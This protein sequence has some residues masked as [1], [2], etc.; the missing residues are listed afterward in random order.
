MDCRVLPNSV[1]PDPSEVRFVVPPPTAVVDLTMSDGAV[2]RVRRHGNAGGNR[3]ILSHGNGFAIDAYFPFW[4]RLVRDFEII[5]FDQRNHGWN[6]R[7][8]SGHTQAQMANDMEIILRAVAAEFGPRPIAGAFHSL[9]T[10]VSLLHAMKYSYRWDALILFDPPL[11]PPP[12]HR[13]HKRARDF[14]LALSQWSLHRQRLFRN[15]AE[16]ADYFKNARRLRHWVPG[17]AELM[18]SAVTRPAAGGGVELVCPPELEADIYVQNSNAPAWQALPHL[19]KDL[20]V[21]SS[22]PDEPHPD[23]PGLVS[24]ALRADFGISV[25]PVRGS[26]HLLMIEQPEAVE[27]V[28]RG[29]LRERGFA[30]G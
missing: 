11:A 23:P 28:L 13:L 26:G 27:H 17:A 30:V 12:G 1:G 25:V 18:A 16:L 15:T 8:T 9:S 5:L 24:Q 22:D 2:I 4:Q 19:A 29:H 7:H 3:L 20:F 14:E 10:T 6:P 21:I